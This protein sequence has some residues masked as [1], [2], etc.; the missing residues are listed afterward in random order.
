MHSLAYQHEMAL[1]LP[2]KVRRGVHL[3]DDTLGQLAVVRPADFQKPLV[4]RRRG[5]DRSAH[6]AGLV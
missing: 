2:L 6:W 3:V 4:V 1:L 5:P